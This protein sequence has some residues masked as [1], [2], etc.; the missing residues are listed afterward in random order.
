MKI[1]RITSGSVAPDQ[2][3]GLLEFWKKII[4]GSYLERSILISKTPPPPQKKIFCH[5]TKHK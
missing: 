2:N 4:P 5:K 3:F 1:V